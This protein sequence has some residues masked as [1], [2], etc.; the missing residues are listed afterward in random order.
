MHFFSWLTE[1]FG[2]PL[3]KYSIENFTIIVHEYLS[4][5]NLRCLYSETD[6]TELLYFL[7]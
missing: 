7:S 4:S 2:T 6:V 3:H 5:A 1:D